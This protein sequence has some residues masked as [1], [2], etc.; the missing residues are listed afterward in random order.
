MQVL[1]AHRRVAHEY[2]YLQNIV[3]VWRNHQR[4]AEADRENRDLQNI[5]DPL[6]DFGS[7][8]DEK[9]QAL[10]RRNLNK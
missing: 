2:S 7:F 8:V 6:K 9:L 3:V 1:T 5:A 4:R 10:H